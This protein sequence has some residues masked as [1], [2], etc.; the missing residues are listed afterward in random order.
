[1][2]FKEYYISDSEGKSN[3]VIRS[4]CKV[5]N[6]SYDK[7]YNDLVDISKELNCNFNDVEVFEEYM[8]RHN[9]Y[10]YFSDNTIKVKDLDLD[11]GSY[12]VFCWDRDKYYH[13]VSIIDNTLYD[14]DDRS[15]DLYVI[16]VYKLN[17]M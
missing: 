2:N 6:E 10:N 16:N 12:V 14:K 9:T 11:N 1:M 4:F 3:C 7:V 8:S 13:M 17:N 5:Y 15:L